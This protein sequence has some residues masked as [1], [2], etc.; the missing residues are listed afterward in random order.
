MSEYLSREIEMYTKEINKRLCDV[1]NLLINQYSDYTFA[2]QFIDTIASYVDD[3]MFLEAQ[4]ILDKAE[5]DPAA[6]FLLPQPSYPKDELPEDD[7]PFDLYTAQQD[8]YA[9]DKLFWFG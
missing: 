5:Q 1:V 4:A 8:N 2:T 6:Y 7:E 3:E 9:R